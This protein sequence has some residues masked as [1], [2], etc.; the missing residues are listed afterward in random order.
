MRDRYDVVVLGAGPG[1]E[2]LAGRLVPHGVRV[3][4]I[5]RELVGGEC[6]YW[7]CIPSKT[8]IRPG[9]ARLEARRAAGL[10]EPAQRLADL[11][12]YRDEM[13]RHLDDSAYVEGLR[14]SGVDVVRGVGRLD[15][16]GRVVVGDRVLETDRVVVATGSDPRIPDVPGLREAGYWTN[17]EATTL[18]AVP[19]SIVVLGGGPV[20]VELAQ[21][22]RRF[23]SEVTLVEGGGRLLGRESSGLGEAVARALEA[24][25]VTVHLGARAERVERVD[26]GR[27]VLLSD[28]TTISAEQLLVAVG[29]TPRTAG[30]GLE[31]IGVP[32][33]PEGI[34]VDERC[35]VVDGVWAIGD[36]TGLLPFTHVAKYQARIVLADILGRPA[37]ADLRAVPRVVFSDPEVAAV[38]L[39]EE[40]AEADA[41]IDLVVGSADLA[42]VP[43][44][45]TYGRDVGGMLR[46]LVDR[47]RGVLVGAWAVGPLAGEWIHQAVLAV[48]TATPVDV[49]RDTV[50]QFPTFSEAYLNALEALPL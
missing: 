41:S 47:R 20:G 38:G 5:E 16:P 23:G 13:V 22:L 39:T 4:L 45:Y 15:G 49:L 9:E 19:E 8:L 42:G 40:Q 7:A 43:R 50:P 34:E 21:A 33:R 25:G 27:R 44:S 30:I 36:V 31:T 37:R 48:K 11:F 3:A 32:V 24:D 6:S 46:L 29:R 28:G 35:R 2:A 1:G 12:A 10:E 17:R 18:E 26:G 14:E